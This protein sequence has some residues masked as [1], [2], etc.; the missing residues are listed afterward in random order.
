MRPL[1]TPLSSLSLPAVVEAPEKGLNFYGVVS[2]ETAAA[3]DMPV[4][5]QTL[6]VTAPQ[7]LSQAETDQVQSALA[8]ILG[9]YNGV[10]F[11]K[12]PAGN[13]AT[14][15]WLIVLGGALITLSAAGITAGL[16]LADGRNDHAT[17]AS[18][19][20]DPRLR[21]ALSASQTLMTAM[22]GT[23]LGLFAGAVPVLVVLSMQR[24][25]PLVIPWLQMGTLLVLVP[26]FGAAAAWLLTR[27]TLPMT[28]RQTLV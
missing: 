8:P 24:G 15:L 16:A 12:G 23:V 2:P 5:D 6:L 7:K 27:G 25:Y 14:I 17:L 26:L 18:I 20:A 22:L 10:Y 28:R 4:S 3:M 1:V 11:E 13:I 21:K 19:G 9:Q